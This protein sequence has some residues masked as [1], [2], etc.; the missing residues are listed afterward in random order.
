[1]KNVKDYGVQ[2]MN[3]DEMKLITGGLGFLAFVVAGI[4]ISAAVEIISDWDNFIGGLT[5]Q[6]EIP[7]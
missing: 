5:G 7:K 2:E 1:M 4:I 3:Q 6:C